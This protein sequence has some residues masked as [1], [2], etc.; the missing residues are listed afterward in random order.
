MALNDELSSVAGWMSIACW[1]IVYTPQIY[2]NYTLKSGEGLSVLF[3]VIWLAGDLCNLGGALMAGLIPTVIILAVYYTLCDLTLLGQIYYYRHVHPTHIARVSPTP[4]ETD[5]LLSPSSSELVATAKPTSSVWKK[6]LIYVLAVCFVLASGAIAWAV[7]RGKEV[8]TPGPG[9]GEGDVLE[10]KSQLIGWCSAVLY[11]GSRI[12]QILKNRETKCAG[13]SLALFIFAVAGNV[14]YVLSICIK[15]MQWRYLL[16]NSSW[17]AGS[18]LT[19]FL[20]FI[21]LG[22]FFYYRKERL[23]LVEDP[24]LESEES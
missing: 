21:V 19:V 13:L 1:I 20:D 9:E 14:T 23:A 3:V 22:Q 6:V 10:W 7:T 18:G 12:P 8:G 2:E 11:L 5:P 24:V 17:L 15:S 4:S 16:A